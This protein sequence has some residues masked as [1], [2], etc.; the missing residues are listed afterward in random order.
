[1]KEEIQVIDNN[2]KIFP[3]KY[4]LENEIS[5]ND[6]D[7]LLDNKCKNLLYSI[8]IGMFR[9]IKSK[10]SNEEI[11]SLIHNNETWMDDYQW[12]KDQYY[13]YENILTKIIKKIYSYGDIK[14]LSIAQW[15][16]TLFGFKLKNQ[17]K[18]QIIKK[19]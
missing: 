9:F 7:S 14:A 11:I 1:M 3:I 15:Y 8:I 6:I 10:K 19:G 12:S 4:L 2:I 17:K 13:Q 5:E 16:I 18:K